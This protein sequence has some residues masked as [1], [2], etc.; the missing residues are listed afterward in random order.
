MK[1]LIGV[2]AGAAI[3]SAGF[4]TSAQAALLGAGCSHGDFV[5]GDCNLATFGGGLI[6]SIATTLSNG[7]T[8][9]AQ[10]YYSG[11]NG[12]DDPDLEDPV[13]VG[14]SQILNPTNLLIVAANS[15][16]GGD[17]GGNST[18]A[19]PNDDA[20]GG[21]IVLTSAAGF[22]LK[23]ATIVVDRESSFFL[24]A[25]GGA[26]TD[27]TATTGNGQWFNYLA[28]RF[29]GVAINSLAITYTRDSGGIALNVAPIPIPAPLA[30]LLSGMLGLGWLGSRRRRAA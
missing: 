29:A 11:N 28:T 19:D 20:Q 5:P 12:G 25:N 27:T 18:K 24:S 16:N 21:T 7:N 8:G 4:G 30:L 15:S 10:I 26:V 14:G 1:T 6:D 13:I 23:G 3:L 17:A 2:I 22:F 9:Q